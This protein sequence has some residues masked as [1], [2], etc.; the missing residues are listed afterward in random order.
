MLNLDQITEQGASLDLQ[1]LVIL[2]DRKIWT[3]KRT[4]R[5]QVSSGDG[6]KGAKWNERSL[7]WIHLE[8]MQAG[9]S[10]KGQSVA[11]KAAEASLKE[12][13]FAERGGGKVIKWIKAGFG[14]C[15]QEN[16][17]N[18][19]LNLKSCLFDKNSY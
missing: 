12:Y 9:A 11:S 18:K 16:E 19:L 15:W 7:F 17:V 3:A 10:L 4:G 2:K 5:E 1:G 13:S 8:N 6:N 14:T